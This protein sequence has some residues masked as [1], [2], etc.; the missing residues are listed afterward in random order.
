ML[1]AP[2]TRELPRLYFSVS[3]RQKS[4]MQVRR[5]SPLAAHQ[6]SDASTDGGRNADAQ[7]QTRSKRQKAESPTASWADVASSD[8]DFEL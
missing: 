2:L 5:K 4:Q 1:V 6:H 3:N 7:Q 8:D